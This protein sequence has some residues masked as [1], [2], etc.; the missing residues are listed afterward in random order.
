MFNHIVTTIKDLDKSL[1][2][3]ELMTGL[4]TKEKIKKIF[5]LTDILGMEKSRE[6]NSILNTMID[7]ISPGMKRNSDIICVIY[8]DSLGD[9]VTYE[10]K[11]VIKANC[12]IIQ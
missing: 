8:I 3:Y 4:S 5:N 9:L 11:D 10:K 7:I 2:K 12:L 1:A 6:K